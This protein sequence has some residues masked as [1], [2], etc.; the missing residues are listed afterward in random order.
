MQPACNM[1]HHLFRVS[2]SILFGL[3]PTLGWSLDT[4]SLKPRIHPKRTLNL[5]SFL[6]NQNETRARPC[7]CSGRP[8]LF[9]G[10]GS[11]FT[12][13]W[14]WTRSRQASQQDLSPGWSPA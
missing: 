14:S 1:L 4:R 2:L 9:G 11:C 3:Y 12:P 6:F 10:R 7:S 8:R 5:F 13:S